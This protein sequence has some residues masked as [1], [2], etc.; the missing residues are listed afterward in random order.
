MTEPEEQAQEQEQIYPVTGMTCEHC[1]RAVTQE[2]ER[3]AGVSR[4]SVDL[5][6]GR[7]TLAS[8]RP[9]DPGAVAAAVE[10]AGY[11]VGK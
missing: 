5:A 11:Q 7:A 4:V 1:V 9:L 6:T 8:D 2:L 10:E 3:L